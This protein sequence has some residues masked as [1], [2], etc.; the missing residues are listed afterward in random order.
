MEKFRSVGL[1]PIK[2]IQSIHDIKKRK[3]IIPLE[4]FKEISK[5]NYNT[6]ENLKSLSQARESFAKELGF[7][8]YR[9]Y[10][11]TY[12]KYW[13]RLSSNVS[14]LID[15]HKN[16]Q[17]PIPLILVV[18]TDD[19]Y[20][21]MIK[22]EYKN[23]FKYFSQFSREI[24]F[25]QGRR[26]SEINIYDVVS[27]IETEKTLILENA[28]IVFLDSK[29]EIDNKCLKILIDN[30]KQENEKIVELCSKILENGE[31]LVNND[32]NITTKISMNEFMHLA[33]PNFSPR[34]HISPLNEILKKAREL[35]GVL[36]I[37]TT[38]L[39]DFNTYSE[40]KE[41]EIKQAN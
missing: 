3:Q 2:L 19:E 38:S 6:T 33:H 36:H 13:N 7:D 37:E 27:N 23:D 32:G 5:I 21:E 17:T 10:T 40:L 8:C 18:D 35:K 34:K 12:Y 26:F 1:K 16:S 4:T 28:N 11:H 41:E 24:L 39:E 20:V 31:T 14:K 30:K 9:A 29:G 15:S 22:D 25:T